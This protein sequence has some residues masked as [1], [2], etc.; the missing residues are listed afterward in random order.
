MANPGTPLKLQAVIEEQEIRG[1]THRFTSGLVSGYEWRLR[2]TKYPEK[3]TAWTR[4]VFGSTLSVDQMLAQ[5]Q[6]YLATH[7]HLAKSKPPGT[8]A[9]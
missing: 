7:G 9:Q 8:S 1:V 6:E 2:V 4:W 3:K 5:W